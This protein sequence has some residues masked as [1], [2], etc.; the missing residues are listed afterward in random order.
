MAYSLNSR[1]LYVKLEFMEST[2]NKIKLCQLKGNVVI[3]CN[4]SQC[5]YQVYGDYGSFVLCEL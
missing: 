2:Y 4:S 5:C 3:T 1:S